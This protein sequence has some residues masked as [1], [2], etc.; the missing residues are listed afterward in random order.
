[1][2]IL[3]NLNGQMLALLRGSGSVVS[4]QRA[5]VKNATAGNRPC[6]RRV[7][8][9]EGQAL[10]EMAYMLPWLLVLVLG[11]FIMGKYISDYQGVTDATGA[12]ARSLARARSVSTDPCADAYAAFTG[13]LATNFSASNVTNFTVTVTNPSDG[14]TSFTETGTSCASDASKL[15][16]GGDNAQVSVTYKDSCLI[17][18]WAGSCPNINASVTEYVY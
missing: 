2:K 3:T 11:V 1:M 16:G 14:T 9:E 18:G 8:G 12:A 13:A 5:S 6:V 4:S 17:P 15:G 10:V 7:H